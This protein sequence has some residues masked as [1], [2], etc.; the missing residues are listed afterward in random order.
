MPSDEVR[1]G[2]RDRGKMVVKRFYAVPR[3]HQQPSPQAQQDA[4]RRQQQAEE[5][6]Q[7]K[8][9][10]YLHEDVSVH[11][12]SVPAALNQAALAS[13]PFICRHRGS[14]TDTN[15]ARISAGTR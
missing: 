1:F 3:G 2:Q 10:P 6:V 11:N 13:P 5:D 4:G 14:I 9:S 7:K 12:S 8:A 15:F